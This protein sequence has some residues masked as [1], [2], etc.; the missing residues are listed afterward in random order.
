[1]KLFVWEEILCD[2]SCG[3]GFALADNIE[4]ARNLIIKKYCPDKTC[5]ECGFGEDR[6]MLVE[7]LQPEPMIYES[8]IGYYVWGGG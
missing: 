7:D 8:P 3:I 6:C 1:M 5:G 2:Y 4:E